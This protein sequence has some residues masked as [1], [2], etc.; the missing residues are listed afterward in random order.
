MIYLQRK[1]LDKEDIISTTMQQNLSMKVFYIH[2]ATKV[3]MLLWTA[4]V[5]ILVF[6]MF[7]EQYLHSESAV[8]RTLSLKFTLL[9]TVILSL[10]FFAMH[11]HF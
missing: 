8:N 4:V 1:Y 5:K 7:L 11:Y 3:G 2:A 10:A 9:Y 6:D